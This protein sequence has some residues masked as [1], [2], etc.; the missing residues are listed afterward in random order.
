MK[1]WR[2][3]ES[4]L[5]E[6]AEGAT[7]CSIPEAHQGAEERSPDPQTYLRWSRSCSASCRCCST[8]AC[9]RRAVSLSCELSSQRPHPSLGSCWAAPLPVGE[10]AWP[11]PAPS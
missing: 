4:F 5:W 9:S 2:T 1:C 6:D 10:P 8:S 3:R 11:G 7:Q